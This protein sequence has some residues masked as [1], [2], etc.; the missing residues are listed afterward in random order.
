M[1]FGLSFSR[2]RKTLSLPVISPD[3]IGCGICVSRCRKEVLEMSD[4]TAECF[5]RV[6]N[7]QRCTG[8]SHCMKACPEEAIRI[9]HKTTLE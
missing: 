7:P 3:C 9:L 8:C 1:R 5:V 4:N 6:S 2:K